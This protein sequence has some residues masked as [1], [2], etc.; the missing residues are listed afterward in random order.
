VQKR[1]RRIARKLRLAGSWPVDIAELSP[2]SERTVLE[3]IL[4]P[5]PS[6]SKEWPVVWNGRPMGM[7][8]TF[9]LAKYS[10]AEVAHFAGI[11]TS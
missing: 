6:G 2:P 5:G 8:M 11:V 1:H 10:E 4:D 9:D 7:L 3:T